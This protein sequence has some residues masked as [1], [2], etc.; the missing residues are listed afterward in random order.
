MA[1]FKAEVVR[2]EVEEHPN[3]DALELARVGDYLSVVR[4]DQFKTGDLA[5]YIPEQA[6]LPEWLITRLGLEGRLAGKQKNRVKAVKLRGVLSQGLTYPVQY[7]E[8][9]E[10]HYVELDPEMIGG[11]PLRYVAEGDDVT[12]DLGLV[13]WEPEI[14]AHMNGEVFNASDFTLKYDIENIK[15]YPNVF[16]E[17]ELVVV[18]E[19]LHGTWACFGFHPD[20]PHP[21]VTSK[22]MSAKGL[23]FKFNEQNENNLYVRMFRE[24]EDKL[25]KLLERVEERELTRPVYILGEIYGKGIQ[26]LSYGEMKPQFRAF[27]VYI[28]EPG[29]GVYVSAFSLKGWLGEMGIE[30][31]PVLHVGPFDRE[32]IDELTNGSETV[33]GSEFNIREGVVIKSFMEGVHPEIGRKVLKSVSEAY[34]LR[35]GGTEFN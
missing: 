24:M 28:G 8:E 33:S 17:H 21:I 1:D 19:K 14:P 22:G 11:N 31:V 34:L 29:S 16:D 9:V 7:S 3:A 10:R 6:V 25:M 35:K 2:I 23:A 4:K 26:D 27:D 32:L 5:V 12:E 13:K 30:T 20:A 15:K 18:T